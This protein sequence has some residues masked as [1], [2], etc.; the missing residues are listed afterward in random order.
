MTALREPESGVTGEIPLN[1]LAAFSPPTSKCPST[2][3]VIVDD[4]EPEHVLDSTVEIEEC[5]TYGHKDENREKE[6]KPLAQR[7]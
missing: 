1:E 5:R 3:V 2:F 4:V 6:I 7:R